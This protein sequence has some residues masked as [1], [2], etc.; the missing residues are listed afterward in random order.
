MDLIGEKS[1]QVARPGSNL[2]AVS[3]TADP[4]AWPGQDLVG[5][6]EAL[7]R[8]MVLDGEGAQTVSE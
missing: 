6:R 7:M 2:S 3:E 8:W 1:V 4:A 5:P